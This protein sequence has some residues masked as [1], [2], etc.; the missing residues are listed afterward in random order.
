MLGE[1]FPQLPIHRQFREVKLNSLSVQN[2]AAVESGERQNSCSPS[3]LSAV[4]AVVCRA[5]PQLSSFAAEVQK[6]LITLL[7]CMAF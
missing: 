4:V 6:L 1:D 7:N 5:S 2:Q 3:S